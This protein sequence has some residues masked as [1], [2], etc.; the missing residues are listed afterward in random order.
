M[1]YHV[2]YSKAAKEDIKDIYEYIAY[3]LLAPATAA[4][5]IKRIIELIKSLSEMPM[6]FQRYAEEPWYSLG[7]RVVPVNN[8]LVFYLP[9]EMKHIVKIIRVMYSGRDIKTQL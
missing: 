2:L 5:Q 3:D 6:R 8:Y 9:D 4:S 7:L 1:I